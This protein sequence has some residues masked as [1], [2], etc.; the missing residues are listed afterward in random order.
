MKLWSWYLKTFIFCD[1]IRSLS[2]FIHLNINP[3]NWLKKLIICC[4]V[5]RTPKEIW[6]FGRMWQ[7]KYA[8]ALPKNLEVGVDFRLCSDAD[9]R[10]LLCLNFLVKMGSKVW[11]SGIKLFK[12]H[13][14]QIV[15]STL[16]HELW[17]W[18]Q[19]VHISGSFWTKMLRVRLLLLQLQS[20]AV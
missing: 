15:Y 9:F 20:S 16:I 1:I 2:D 3:F 19:E 10:T 5:L 4:H 8:S 17:N 13:W 12:H 6:K 18:C 11:I 7:T 14:K